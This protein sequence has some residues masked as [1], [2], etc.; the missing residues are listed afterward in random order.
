MSSAKCKF[1]SRFARKRTSSASISSS[2]LGDIGQQRGNRHQSAR[3]RRECPRGSPCAAGPRVHHKRS[4]PVDDRDR[5]LTGRQQQRRASADAA[6]RS[7][8]HAG[9]PTPRIAAR[10]RPAVSAPVIATI[11]A[12]VDRKRVATAERQQRVER[13]TLARRPRSPAPATLVDQVEADVRRARV[14]RA[15]AGALAC[16]LDRLGATSLS[17]QRAAPCDLL[18]RVAVA[19]RASRSPSSRERRPGRRAVS[20]RPR[21]SARRTRASRSRSESAGCRCCC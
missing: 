14:G 8:Q 16:E 20:S 13:R 1:A 2:T 10:Q 17:D 19:D 6:V 12:K 7:M 9:R 18:G 21:S 5:E 11:V 4:E 15:V 3:F